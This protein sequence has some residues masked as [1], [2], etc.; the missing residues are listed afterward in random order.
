M[1]DAALIET[2]APMVAVET[3]QAIVQVESQG[4]PL[5]LNANRQDGAVTLHPDDIVS[6][7]RLATQEIHA[8]NSVDIGLMQ[9]N[10]RNLTKLGLTIPQAFNPC[11][12]LKAGASVLASAYED[13]VKEQ[14]EGQ[15]ALRAALSAY[16]TGNYVA[17]FTNGY[18]ARYYAKI[19]TTAGNQ[20]ADIYAA[21][22][23]VFFRTP[24]EQTMTVE[25]K[26]ITQPI[27]VNDY[28]EFLTKGVQVA[29]DP[30]EA[31]ALGAIEE[32]ALSEADAWDSQADR[33]AFES[34]IAPSD[35][36]GR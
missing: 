28:N 10:S 17:G 22:P 18:V 29:L 9:I 4:D 7:V 32:H 21:D 14:G 26:T 35:V 12:N 6:A 5:A 13:A 33:S 1:I 31:E 34:P 25:T 30:L 24:K 36:A 15:P 8:G 19:S 3:I 23:T 2:C 20:T 16:N 27:V 11:T